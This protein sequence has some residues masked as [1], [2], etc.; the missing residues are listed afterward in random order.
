MRGNLIAMS[1]RKTSLVA[2]QRLPESSG[3]DS[4]DSLV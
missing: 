1:I 2:W 3:S 4:S